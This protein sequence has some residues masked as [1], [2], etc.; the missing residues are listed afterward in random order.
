MAREGNGRRIT[1]RVVDNLKPGELRWDAEL[2]GFG[3]RCQRAAKVY[4]I[5]KRVGGRQRWISIGR[6]GSPWTPESARRE[7]QRLLGEIAVGNDPSA[8]RDAEKNNPLVRD[9]IEAYLHEHVEAK[10]KASTAVGYRDLMTRIA[11]PAVGR[12]RVAEV[13][14]SDMAR[15]HHNLK[16]APYQANRTLAVLSSFFTWAERHGYRPRDTN[17]CRDVEPYKERKRDR[18]LSSEELARLGQALSESE[19]EGKPPAAIAAIRLL[20]LTG[21]RKSEILTLQW[22]HV[23]FDLGA[24]R[25]PD[26]KTGAKL[27][28][29]GAPALELLASLPRLE[30]NSYVVPGDNEGRHFVGLQKVWERV[31]DRAGLRD[32]RIHDL[33][34]SFA[35]IGAIRGD[36]L[37][38]IGAL[39]GHRDQSTTQRYAHLSSDPLRAAADRISEQIAAVMAGSENGVGKVVSLPKRH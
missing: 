31:R 3:V 30:G 9:L 23:D 28:P 12:L 10:R 15:L 24:L 34:H 25:L 11:L 20:I 21:C 13:T 19:A 17:P 37:L 22:Q 32:V 35:S 18:F 8:A 33:R 1:K 27:V 4:V 38:V 5:K 14:H 26:S 6:H 7:A 2:K 29:L 16:D 36:S 39:L